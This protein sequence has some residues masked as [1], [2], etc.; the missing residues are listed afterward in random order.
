MKKS[1]TQ[2]KALKAT[3][4]GAVAFTPVLAVTPTADAATTDEAYKAYLASLYDT[5]TLKSGAAR[6]A[7]RDASTY[8]ETNISDAELNAMLDKNLSPTEQQAASR[9]LNRFFDLVFGLET[10]FV[11]AFDSFKSANEADIRTLFG[12]DVTAD[13]IADFA[14]NVQ[15]T[16]FSLIRASNVNTTAGYISAYATALLSN[17]NHPT[18]PKFRSILDDSNTVI[19]ELNK[20]AAKP[21]FT[22]EV[23]PALNF[24]QQALREVA[25]YTPPTTNPGT[26]GTPPVVVGGELKVDA[27]TLTSN[28]QA[29]IAAI[30]AA[31]T[32]EELVITLPAGVEEVK[33]PATILA[34]LR[35]KNPDAVIVVQTAVGSYNLPVSEINLAAAAAQLGVT[36]SELSLTVKV[37]EITNP[38]AGRAGLNVLAPAVDFSV[39]L[40]DATGREY[41]INRFSKPVSRALVANGTLNPTTT[42]GVV[43]NPATGEFTP[44]PTFATIV[45]GKNVAVLKRNTNSIYT[46]IENFQTFKDVDGGKSW[47]E[48]YVEKLASRMIVKGVNDTEFKPSAFITRGEFAALLSRGLGITAADMNKKV[49]KDVTTDQAANKNGEV[50]AAVEAGV[51]Q[52][53][54]DGTFRPYDRIT[55]DQAAIMIS[56]AIAY[57]GDDKV[58]FEKSKN[59]TDF[60]DYAAIGA[61]ARPH[62]ERVYEAGYIEG[63]LDDTFRPG[64]E[65]NRAQMAKILYNFLQ[66]VKHIN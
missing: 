20:I 16:Y 17:T 28:P 54:E 21:G 59:S 37:D 33:V 1:I 9:V 12:T 39:S 61:T 10:N 5:T 27:G 46:V 23:T 4:V 22:S 30:N 50:Y 36:Q 51:I 60:N 56:R 62:V 34:A 15:A 64:A 52:G 31:T 26:P 63:F 14:A 32:I 6:E 43:Y 8:L 13:E 49:F 53:Y 45:D 41:V 35:A 65:T 11:T 29:I 3:L 19:A 44:V 57:L 48:D 25:P 58:T 55:R 40:T 42:L 47:A 66:S 38:L 2:S 7:F 24:L 18:Y